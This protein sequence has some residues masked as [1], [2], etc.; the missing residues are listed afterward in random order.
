MHDHRFG[1]WVLSFLLTCLVPLSTDAAEKPNVLLILVD[2]LK[3]SFGAYGDQWV[4][5]PNLDRLAASGMRFDRA[6]CNQAVCAPSRNNLLVGSRS[7]SIGVYSLGNHF[8]NAVP[9]AV[10]MPQHFK[11]HGYHAA[12]IGKVFHI[13]HGNINDERSWSV[14][15]HPDKVIDYV[16]PA[17]TDGQ[18]TREEALFSNRSAAGL[19]R[20]AAWEIVEVDDGAY[21]DGRIAD[22]GIKRL[23]AY[24][25]S[26]QPFFLALGFTKPH[27][28]FCAP[29]KYWD[30]YEQD[31]LPLAEFTQPPAGA[32][33]YAGKTI[34]ELNQYK[35]VPQTP[36]LGEDLTRTL[37]H[38]YY[39]ALSY[40]DAQLGRVLD[41]LERLQLDDNTIVVL[42]GD[43]GYHLG[44]HG[45]WTKH[46]N[47]EQANRIPI[48]IRA[49]GVTR[50]GMHTD[51]LVETVDL[52]PTI[53]E[54]AGLPVPQGPQPIDGESLVNSLRGDA[55]ADPGHAYHCFPKGGRLGRAIRTSRYRLVEWTPNSG[56]GAVEYELYDY[57]TDPLETRNLADSHPNVV[58]D[59]TKLLRTHPEPKPATRKRPARRRGNAQSSQPI[60]NR[61]FDSPPVRGANLSLTRGKLLEGPWEKPLGAS[62]GRRWSTALYNANIPP[63]DRQG[64]P[65]RDLSDTAQTIHQLGPTLVPLDVRELHDGSLVI[66]AQDV[67]YSVPGPD[68][69]QTF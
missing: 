29:R 30:L 16:L 26:Q 2:D 15:F 28:P 57:Q 60:R 11:Q 6:Y 52:F 62:I 34:G 13:G 47:Y 48:L 41:E 51:R 56:E 19:P 27:L 4:H 12:G 3:P 20:G 9:D 37:I 31:K 65:T 45:T 5:S 23:R 18:L 7:T 59:L 8:R 55:I 64:I 68:E 69:A 14:P 32:P 1:C 44:D 35:P 46:T 24:Q 17:S 61:E 66:R 67:D 42:W 40:M 10:T 39:A 53:A 49:P 63:L 38:G 22:E 50:P 36:P 21:A 58:Q 43:H 54:L 33:R 25:D